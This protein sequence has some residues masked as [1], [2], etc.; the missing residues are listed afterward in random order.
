MPP[1]KPGPRVSK[2]A[3]RRLPEPVL[4]GG[5]F[6]LSEANWKK[7]EKEFVR[8][9]PKKARGEIIMATTRMLQRSEAEYHARPVSESI[10]HITR[11]G[12]AANNLLAAWTVS[13]KPLTDSE[14]SAAV[15]ADPVRL[16]HARVARA[17]AIAR[18]RAR[19]SGSIRFAE[20]AIDQ[21]LSNVTDDITFDEFHDHLMLFVGACERAP[22]GVASMA[23]QAVHPQAFDDWIRDLRDDICPR[24]ELPNTARK[25]TYRGDKSKT[26]KPSP[27]VS[28]VWE[29]LQM[30]DPEYR[31]VPLSPEALAKAINNVKPRFGTKRARPKKNKSRN[32]R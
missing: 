15:R 5:F 27:F 22:A 24:Y 26:G 32:R 6:K 1:K 4:P 31:Y 20:A 25:D 17:N 11:L 3:V 29:F 23:I 21:E 10:K 8:K 19:V 13:G 28:F 30:I 7:L 18:A 14:F 9:I 12:K 2:S 16:A